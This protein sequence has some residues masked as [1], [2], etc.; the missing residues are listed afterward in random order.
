MPRISDLPNAST[1]SGAELIPLVQSGTT[2]R[3]IFDDFVDAVAIR[4]AE[5]RQSGNQINIL[6]YIPP[7]EYAAIFAGTSTYDCYPAIMTAINSQSV[8]SGF[9]ISGPSIY[10]PNGTYKVNSTIELK[11]SVRLYGDGSGLPNEGTATLVF[12]AGVTGIIV[13]RYNTT[14][15]TVE[16]VPTTGG[17]ASVI[18]GLQLYGAYSATP[19]AAGGVGIWLR[20]RAHCTKNLISSFSGHGYKV[21][22]TAGGGGNTE[23]NANNF[24]INGGR[25][26]L[27]GEWGCYIEGADANAGYILGLDCSANG[28]G[29]FYDN[30]FL[31]NTY[32]ACHSSDNGAANSAYNTI[33]GRTSMVW[34]GGVR[35]YAKFGATQAQLVATTPGT[36]ETKWVTYTAAGAANATHPLWVAAQPVGTYFVSNSYYGGNVNGR[37]MF[38]NCYN[39]A[40]YSES[41]FVNPSLIIGGLMDPSSG[42]SRITVTTAGTNFNQQ[43]GATVF[44]PTTGFSQLDT[45]GS[46][47]WDFKSPG[48]GRINY[49]WANAELGLI[50]LYDRNAT[51]ANGYARTVTTGAPGGNSGSLGIGAHY[52]GSRTQMRWRG[53]STSAPATGDY[54]QGD[55]VWNS[56]PTAGGTLGWVC[57][58]AGNP[59]TWKTFGGIAP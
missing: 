6:D 47:S 31:G 17:D 13:H 44:K 22:A 10:F 32:L 50:Q 24:Q 57:T 20:A 37:N 2:K 53:L 28:S 29:G 16:G 4:E 52:F 14:G 30:S 25:C 15:A 40:G 51:T 58:T 49:S 8:G 27:N 55:I 3:V 11:K 34:F 38:L 39:E 7:T 46:F 41:F 9:Y 56:A 54:I 48:T 21:L 33:R 45:S 1:L 12:P 36:D 43:V 42:G 23:G 35:Y 5:L 18:E 19:D 26:T 59:G